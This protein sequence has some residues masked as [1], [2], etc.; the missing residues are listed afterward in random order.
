MG[1]DRGGVGDQEGQGIPRTREELE[2]LRYRVGGAG[3]RR[4][5]LAGTR[6]M[7]SGNCRG[8]H[9]ARGNWGGRCWVFVCCTCLRACGQC[10]QRLEAL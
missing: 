2:V 7:E 8:E 1:V 3:I 5:R 6:G 4:G 9:R 10:E